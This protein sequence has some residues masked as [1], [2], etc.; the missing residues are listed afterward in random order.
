[1]WEINLING[2]KNLVIFEKWFEKK[3][4]NLKTNPRTEIIAARDSKSLSRRI[5]DGTE[6]NSKATLSM[7]FTRATKTTHLR[8]TNEAK[9]KLITCCTLMNN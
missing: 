2:T 7:L 9:P 1:M 8:K 5:S 6:E 4:K 3:D